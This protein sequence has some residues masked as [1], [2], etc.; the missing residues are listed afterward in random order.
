MG[1]V[2]HD[3]TATKGQSGGAR[4]AEIGRGIEVVL[5]QQQIDARRADTGD[6]RMVASRAMQQDA[7]GFF[8]S[9]VD[10]AVYAH[11]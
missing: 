4:G 6:A 1:R 9:A 10:T 7:A 11:H 8:A 3:V 2:V 5:M